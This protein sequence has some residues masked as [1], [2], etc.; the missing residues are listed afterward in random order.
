M[1]ALLVLVLLA[2][3]AHAE[4]P[5]EQGVS[6]AQQDKANALFREANALFAE[7]AHPA[8]LEKYRAAVALWDHPMIRFNMAVTL[9]RLDQYLEAAEQ[10][11]KALRY[12]ATPFT[13]ELYEQA[14][15]YQALVT[16]QLGYIDVTCTEPGTHITLDGKPL[17]D[18]PGTKHI[19][20]TSGEHSIV[21]EKKGFM[22]V[23]RSLVIVGGT[24]VKESV[25]M[26]PVE[27]ALVIEYKHP[28]W[29]PW[30][31]TGVGAALAAGGL[32]LVIAGNRQ[33]DRFSAAFVRECPSGCEAGLT[34]HQALADE[35][36]SAI[37]KSKIG[38]SLLVT[39]GA[40]VVSGIVWGITNRHTR[41]IGPHVEVA[42]TA[43][44]ASASASWRF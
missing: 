43:S 12:G 22:T 15:D 7:K 23:S 20:T 10:L 35:Q 40:A 16:K 5:W 27:A 30:T 11:E 41:T 31:L 21:G 28:R 8:A 6:E 4:D 39:G 37:L 9:I 3:V 44:G 19:R 1:K 18:A 33:M 38:V 36:D 29:M 17:F 32:G 13:P 24:T 14:L 25:Q 26:L 2:G 42:P 34:M